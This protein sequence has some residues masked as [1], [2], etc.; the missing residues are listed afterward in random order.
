VIA[1][2]GAVAMALLLALANGAAAQPGPRPLF[3]PGAEPP[4]RAEPLEAPDSARLDLRAAGDALGADP[5]QGSDPQALVA[6]L[7]P[8]PRGALIDALDWPMRLLAPA[9]PAAADGTLAAD[10]A[11]ALLEL[12]R[13]AAALRVLEALPEPWGEPATRRTA[14]VAGFLADG[15]ERVCPLVSIEAA[16]DAERITEQ[17][18]CGLV[19]DDPGRVQTALLAAREAG[20]SL[21]PATL[22]L[23]RAA[24]DGTPATLGGAA[25]E[26]IAAL[27]LS[28]AVPVDLDP[29]TV[30]ALP[31][32]ARLAL[33]ANAAAPGELRFAAALGLQPPAALG[34]LVREL[35]AAKSP[36]LEAEP[37][38]WLAP[39]VEP[40]EPMSRIAALAAAATA[41]VAADQRAAWLRLLAAEAARLAPE[42]ALLDLAPQLVATLLAGGRLAEARRWT[43]LARAQGRSLELPPAAR[44]AGLDGHTAAPADPVLHAALQAALGEPPA[45]LLGGLAVSAADP[46]GPPIPLALDA[47]LAAAAEA[48]RKGETLLLAARLLAE[49][50]PP[51]GRLVRA[52][53]AL[54]QAGLITEARELACLAWALRPAA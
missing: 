3:P 1:R 49:T 4:I 52:V 47:A 16:T 37:L 20:L 2:R 15:P 17:L 28:R 14:F 8:P 22:A 36:A 50:A 21:P 13:P 29:A 27:L 53:R 7:L 9:L 31:A 5:W 40:A 39:V 43:L 38:R 26:P 24:L 45:G 33:T 35:I 44:L 30:R 25:P 41:P 11:A 48:G 6:L 19:E 23:A 46:D 10:R 34:G 18:V 12:G 51:P 42:P 32:P 54:R